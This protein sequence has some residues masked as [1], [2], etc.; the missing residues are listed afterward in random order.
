M[1]VEAPKTRHVLEHFLRVVAQRQVVAL[2]VAE[3]ERTVAAR[4]DVPDLDVGLAVADVVLAG[5][6]VQDEKT[7]VVMIR[8]RSTGQYPV[9][10]DFVR[11]PD[12]VGDWIFR[13]LGGGK[14]EVT[15]IGRANP[16]GNI[17][18]GVVNLII[19]ETP[20]RTLLGLREVIGAERYQ[21]SRLKQIREWQN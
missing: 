6:I 1:D 16:S 11:M 7:G 14:V 20:Y 15:M 18:F 17:P 8:S 21:R 2:A 5:Q 13:P 4:V 3:G 9:N 10:P 12:M 19:H